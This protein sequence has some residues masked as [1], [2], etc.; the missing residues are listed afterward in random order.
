M[1]MQIGEIR[2]FDLPVPDKFPTAGLV[3]KLVHFRVTLK[4]LKKMDLPELNEE[5]ASQVGEG[6]TVEK[7]RDL[8]QARLQEERAKEINAQK[9]TQIVDYLVKNR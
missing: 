4:A 2:E 6:L 5:F 3:G 8:L 7:L 9:R 1:G